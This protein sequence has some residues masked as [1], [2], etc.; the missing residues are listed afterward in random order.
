MNV[1]TKSSTATSVS[2]TPQKQPIPKTD[3]AL[4]RKHIAHMPAKQRLDAILSAPDCRRVVRLLPVQD[5]YATIAEVGL[6]DSLELVEML[7]PRQVQ[8]CFDLGVWQHSSVGDRVNPVAL[9][10]WFGALR[11]ANPDR[12]VQQMRGLDI[13]LIS[14]LFKLY[15][16]VYDLVAEEEPE[17]VPVLHSVT[18]DNRYLI[19]YLLDDDA[20]Y[21][22]LIR[23]LHQFIE[24]MMGVD[25]L[26][27]LRLAES[28]RWELPSP[29][30]EEALRWRQAR[31]E[32]LG[33]RSADDARILFAPIPPSSV[34]QLWKKQQADALTPAT[35][36]AKDDAKQ[37]Q[38]K[39]NTAPTTPAEENLDDIVVDLSTSVL[40]PWQNLRAD[41]GFFGQ[42]FDK[43]PEADQTRVAAELMALTNMLHLIDGD[44]VGDPDA[45]RATSKRVLDTV[46]IGLAFLAQGKT[47]EAHLPLLSVLSTS[48]H[49]KPVTPMSLQTLFRAGFSL[50]I[51]LGRELRS[52][53]DDSVHLLLLDEPLREV[54]AGLLRKQP[55]FYTGLLP[56]PTNTTG[57]STQKI[58]PRFRHFASL[59]EVALVAAAVNDMVLRTSVVKYLGASAALFAQYDVDEAD[60]PDHR[61]LLATVLYRYVEQ[62]TWKM[63]PI[64]K[65][66]L[67]SKTLR[68]HSEQACAALLAHVKPVSDEISQKINTY[69]KQALDAVANELDEIAGREIATA[70]KKEL[71]S[72]EIG[73]IGAPS[74]LAIRTLWTL[75]ANSAR[76]FTA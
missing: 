58:A 7:H 72:D 32:D 22:D 57:K 12:M 44:D 64:E 48:A 21:E 13:E 23:A 26:F 37:E 1:P 5:L 38:P 75:R 74:L 28:V 9:A 11:A 8:A 17:E 2:P 76:S 67:S 73:A 36:D 71:N 62:Q 29:L 65:I 20:E 30:E 66:S 51:E 54:A 10:R 43:L 53:I 47:D 45:L 68:A 40:L 16:R 35:T 24:R 60:Y 52:R 33:F 41:G 25:M 4:L 50:P 42:I 49:Q 63:A 56:I 3:V 61:T 55:L 39:T 34:A 31:L 18:P 27:V 46:G 6:A 15:T 19:A 59:T 69:A 14:L 70:R